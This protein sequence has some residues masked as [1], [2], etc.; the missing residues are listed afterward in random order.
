MAAHENPTDIEKAPE[1]EKE[2]DWKDPG[3]SLSLKWK[4][5]RDTNKN[6]KKIEILLLLPFTLSLFL[7]RHSICRFYQVTRRPLIF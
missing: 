3:L 1:R 2:R 6:K 7:Y 5:F 4:I